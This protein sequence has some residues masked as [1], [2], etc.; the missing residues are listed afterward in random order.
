MD[1]DDPEERIAE[2]ERLAEA[3][4]AAHEDHPNPQA[5]LG[6][7]TPQTALGEEADRARGPLQAEAAA[8]QPHANENWAAIDS[9]VREFIPE[10]VR[11]GIKPTGFLIK[12]WRVVHPQLQWYVLQIYPNG[13]WVLYEMGGLHSTTYRR[14][15]SRIPGYC[16]ID[17]RSINGL[18]EGAVRLLNG[19][20]V[21]VGTGTPVQRLNIAAQSNHA[22]PIKVH[23][24]AEVLATGQRITGLLKS[25]AD[26]GATA[27]SRGITPSRPE[28]LDAPRYKL[29]IELHFPNMAPIQ[30]QNI[31]PVP[32][33][34][35]P[36]LAIGLQLPCAVDPANPQQLCIVDWD[37]I[38]R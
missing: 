30:A 23:S 38:A 17:P 14:A 10:A 4:A 26:T 19:Q 28:Y 13:K 37:A 1:Q 16:A 25:F 5:G 29:V 15:S 32:P 18:R 36:N 3:R 20:I 22:N 34:Q 21:G 24:A 9:L 35:V 6:F 31:Q 27:R 33:A 11:R 7:D 12:S 2:L 8:R